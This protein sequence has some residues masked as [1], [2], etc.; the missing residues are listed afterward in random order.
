MKKV[1]KSIFIIMIASS[2]VLIIGLILKPIVSLAW[3][4]SEG[5]R[6][7][8]SLEELSDEALDGNIV[9]NSIVYEDTDYEWHKE[10]FNSDVPKG[11]ILNEL[12]FV[13]ARED[14]GENK[15]ADNIWNGNEIEAED[16]KFYFI[17]MYVHNN[18][19]NEENSTAED[20]RVAF[21]IPAESATT[22]RV[23]GDIRSSNAVPS[24]YWD[25][26]DFTSDIPF[27]LEYIYGSANL[28]NNYFQHTD[29]IDNSYRLSDEIVT[30]DNGVLIG[31]DSM[32]GMVPGGYQYSC[33]IGIRVKVVY[34]YEFD[35]ETQVRLANSD[36]KTWQK[37]INANVGDIV[38]FQVEY[39]NR[40]PIPDSS[41]QAAIDKA[42]QYHVALRD[43]LPKSLEYIP[44][45]VIYYN[46]A[47]KGGFIPDNPELFFTKGFDT[48]SYRADANV[49]LHFKA[50]VIDNGLAPGSNTLVNWGQASVGST[51]QQDYARVVVRKMTIAE[52]IITVLSILIIICLI[53][54][55]LLR[56][57]LYLLRKEKKGF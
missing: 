45:S 54:I 9:F 6:K 24:E 27:H 12:N 18:S 14:T 21:Y 29:T 32:N 28:E 1:I 7:T 46:G 49:V 56:Y 19:M 38:E 55:I 5:G 8:Y 22:I 39:I 50:K 34:D 57:K 2:T 37:T 25:Y 20:T 40:N 48:G 4:D 36:D 41:D 30:G 35:V 23:N 52:N 26:V 10:T 16:G 42:T 43:L 13:G 11:T 53:M 31:Y 3:G 17:R 44:E 15:G 47:H 33:Y 51:C